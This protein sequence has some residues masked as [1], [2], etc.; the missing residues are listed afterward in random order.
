MYFLRGDVYMKQG[1]EWNTPLGVLDIKSHDY[2]RKALADYE[3]VAELKP[4]IAPY[5][6]MASLAKALRMTEK[7][8]KYEQRALAQ[9]RAVEQEAAARSA[10]RQRQAQRFVRKKMEEHRREI[11]N[12]FWSNWII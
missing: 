2:A 9:Q 5:G 3:K 6:Y 12:N 7:V 11:Q 4:S 10:A 1:T 8:A